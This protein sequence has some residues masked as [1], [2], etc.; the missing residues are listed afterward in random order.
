MVL[1]QVKGKGVVRSRGWARVSASAHTRAPR[2]THALSPCL[3]RHRVRMCLVTPACARANNPRVRA[4]SRSLSSASASGASCSSSAS[5]SSGQA[6]YSRAQAAAPSPSSTSWAA[7]AAATAAA[8]AAATAA[9]GIALADAHGPSTPLA[10]AQVRG[11]G[12]GGR[13]MGTGLPPP[14]AHPLCLQTGASYSWT[15]PLAARPAHPP[16]T[17]PAP[18]CLQSSLDAAWSDVSEDLRR[19]NAKLPP[20]AAPLVG[21]APRVSARVRSPH[22]SL[23]SSSCRWRAGG[24]PAAKQAWQPA[25]LLLPPP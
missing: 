14:R 20:R 6:S 1:A 2:S 23:H 4:Q 7:T 11:G 3:P 18:A 25:H 8:L 13:G 17:P 19:L 9:S 5:A 10:R 24:E 12:K 22:A 16:H 21:A 15:A